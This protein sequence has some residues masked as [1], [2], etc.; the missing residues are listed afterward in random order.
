MGAF[1]GLLTVRLRN[2][3]F[4]VTLG[5]QALLLGISLRI[6]LAAQVMVNDRGF[7]EMFGQAKIGPFSV[8]LF[9]TAGVVALG[10]VILK[11][12]PF[13][14]AVLATGANPGAARFSGIR[15]SQTK[16]IALV[17]SGVG[18][19]LAGLL[20]TAQFGAASYTLGGSDLLTVIAAVI[21]G[22]TA[23]QEGK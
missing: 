22:G 23:L 19:A 1:N 17:A 18:G 9:W 7:L 13:G 4:V 16:F 8:L 6:T 5:T 20:Y 14:R 12:H 3:S 2:P 10:W 11:W 21:I 15:M